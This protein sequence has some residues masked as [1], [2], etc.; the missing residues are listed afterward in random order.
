[1]PYNGKAREDEWCQV[2]TKSKMMC[3]L[4]VNMSAEGNEAMRIV[5]AIR[6]VEVMRCA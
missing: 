2:I 6:C 1:M 4:G 5:E 3:W